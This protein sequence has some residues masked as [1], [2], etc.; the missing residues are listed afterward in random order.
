MGRQIQ[1]PNATNLSFSFF[2]K[3]KV[4]QQL[5]LLESGKRSF[6]PLFNGRGQG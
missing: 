3:I 1:T 6:F 2:F 4:F 5:G